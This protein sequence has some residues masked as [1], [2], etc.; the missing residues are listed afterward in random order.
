MSFFGKNNQ[1]LLVILNIILA[2]GMYRWFLK[3]IL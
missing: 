2:T 1:S 3:G